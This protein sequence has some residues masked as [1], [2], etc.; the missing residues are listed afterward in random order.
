M[1]MRKVF[2]LL[3]FL[4]WSH[5][6]GALDT[7]SLRKWGATVAVSPG[8]A[9]VVD[10]Y[11]RKWQKETSN[12]SFDVSLQHVAL[13]SDSDAFA[14]DYGY[15]TISGHLKYSFNHGVT[16]H[17]SLD[18]SWGMAEEVDYDSRMGNSL[19][20]YASF[21]R[22]IWRSSRLSLDYSL[23]MGLGYSKHKY[24][25]VHAVDNELIGSRFLIFF[26]AGAHLTWRL[27]G[28]WGL[29]AG[30]DYW[31]LSNGALN[32][33]NKGANII[34]PSLGLTY[35]PY[36][37]KLPAG[38]GRRFNPPFRKYWFGHFA[39]GVGGKSLNEEWLLTQFSTP[40]E[41]PLYR[42]DDFSIYMAYSMQA[43]MM[44]RYVRR[45]ASGIGVDVFYGAY[46]S[47]VRRIDELQGA[48]V[49]HSPWSLGIA[50][51]HQV[52]YHHFSIAMSLGY[53]LYREM[54]VNADRIEKPYYERIGLQYELPGLRGL[55]IGAFVKAHLTKADLTELV[56]SFPV[57]FSTK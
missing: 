24:N 9:L 43:D 22:P 54:G 8:H 11:Q 46:A 44:Y 49:K 13:P 42:T 10:E 31:H 29:K 33:P 12:L 34:G 16:M 15:P 7:D 51:K 17:K 2:L 48:Q 19:A 4:A 35:I 23:S 18:P 50:L 25:K 38:I 20:A 52:Y 55:S 40:R 27:S 37:N 41:D 26:G 28:E 36:Y 32:R 3:V 47:R 57:S 1:T 30:V 21:A 39:V 56:V 14:A 6:A 45:W 5:F 53:Y